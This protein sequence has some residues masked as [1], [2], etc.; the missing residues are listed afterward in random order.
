MKIIFQECVTYLS[1]HKRI[2]LQL[3]NEKQR[4]LKKHRKYKLIKNMANINLKNT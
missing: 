4:L 1:E 2:Y 3:N